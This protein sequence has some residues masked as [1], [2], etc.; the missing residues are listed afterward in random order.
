MG[1]PVPNELKAIFLNELRDRFGQL[2]KLPG[3]QSLFEVGDG[4]ARIYVRYSRVHP[5]NRTFFGL[6]EEDLRA[7]EGRA[8]IICFLWDRQEKPL[9]V[10]YSE[11]EEVFNSTQHAADGQFKVQVYSEPEATELYIAKAGRFNVDA[12]LGWTD[13]EH[14]ILGEGRDIIPVLNHCQV[15][16]IL[17]AIGSHK[18][19][20][21]WVPSSDRDKLDWSLSPRFEAADCLPFGFE[22]VRNVLKEVD[23]MWVKR[24]SRELRALFEVEHSTPIYSGLLRFNDIHLVAPN[25]RPSFTIVSN[26]ERR[27]AFVRQLNRPTFKASGLNAACTFMDYYDAY[28]WFLRVK[29]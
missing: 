11:Y 8:S 14:L 4:R 17:G 27:E 29:P 6:R 23:V 3:S 18:G 5:G 16:T 20:D 26:E 12:H 9:L 19:F 13:L 15:Q 1:G 24:G 25:L 10:P 21:V 28:G 7:L 2:R 22:D